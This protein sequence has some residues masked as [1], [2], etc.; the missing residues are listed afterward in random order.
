MLNIVD[1]PIIGKNY[2]RFIFSMHSHN[3]KGP[4]VSSS[5]SE[6]SEFIAFIEDVDSDYE[7]DNLKNDD[8]KK[9]GKSKYASVINNSNFFQEVITYTPFVP[10]E[11]NK[12]QRAFICSPITPIAVYLYNSVL[13][14]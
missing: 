5:A 8:N 12:Y 2:S 4:I 3:D 1:N 6:D 9:Q 10:I 14:I 7:E 13:L 11:F